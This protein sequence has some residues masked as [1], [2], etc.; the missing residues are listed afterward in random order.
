MAYIQSLGYYVYQQFATTIKELIRVSSL[1]SARLS[2]D[3]SLDYS[4]VT[5][6]L[7]WYTSLQEWWGII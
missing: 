6:T 3:T 4:W 5:R 2:R 7:S 1:P